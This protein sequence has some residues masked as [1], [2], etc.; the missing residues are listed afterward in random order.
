[1]PFELNLFRTLPLHFDLNAVN[2]Q[3][4]E[5][6][7]SIKHKSKMRFSCGSLLYA[8]FLACWICTVADAAEIGKK[9]RAALPFGLQTEGKVQIKN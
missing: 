9:E 1:V 6:L 3:L 7:I 8:A 4:S 2:W 5:K